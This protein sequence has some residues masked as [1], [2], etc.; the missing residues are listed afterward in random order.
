VARAAERSAGR[1]GGELGEYRG[2]ALERLLVAVE[3]IAV[4]QLAGS[5]YTI[6]DRRL[7]RPADVPG[8][9]IG[10]AD[11]VLIAEIVEVDRFDEPGDARRPSRPLRTAPV[12]LQRFGGPQSGALSQAVVRVMRTIPVPSARIPKRSA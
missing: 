1:R 10:Q 8:Q 3:G 7:T 4:G 6:S 5:R 12:R 9:S 11:Y 2:L